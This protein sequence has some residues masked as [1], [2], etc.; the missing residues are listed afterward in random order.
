MKT[1]MGL[2]LDPVGRAGIFRFVRAAIEK[3]RRVTITHLNVHGVNVARVD[4]GFRCM[5]LASDL[6][7]CDGIGVRLAARLA[8][9]AVP[10]RATAT[11]WIFDFCDEF[12]NARIYY[13]GQHP[14]VLEAGLGV[15]RNRM[16]GLQIS[17][18]HGHFDKEGPENEKVLDALRAYAPSIVMV[19]MGMPIQERWIRANRNRIDAPV[20]IA[21]GA[22]LEWVSGRWRRSPDWVNRVGGEWLG[23]LVR[24][25]AHTWRRYVLGNPAFVARFVV[26]L[27]TG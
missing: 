22:L 15:L 11:D 6:V 26:S 23:R 1:F 21:V 14:D 27:L 24:Q 18:H 8:G 16:S 19:G 3:R 9:L 10:E 17:G 7:Y 25:P 4:E 5:N 2:R 13:V 12:R 20:V